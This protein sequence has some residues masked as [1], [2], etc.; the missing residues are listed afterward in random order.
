[1]TAVRRQV[2]SGLGLGNIGSRS[3]KEEPPRILLVLVSTPLLGL[4]H[5][6]WSCQ[7]LR[8]AGLGRRPIEG[9][10][11]FWVSRLRDPDSID[12]NSY[13]IP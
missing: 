6:A 2:P 3:Y 11:N 10:R 4:Q 5:E 12:L 8:D 7:S 13:R 9:L 1:M